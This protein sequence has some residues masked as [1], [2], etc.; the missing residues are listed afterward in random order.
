MLNQIKKFKNAIH[1]YKLNNG[2][3]RSDISCCPCCNSLL[4]ETNTDHIEY[5]L[6]ECT[7]YCP[8]CQKDVGVWAYGNLDEDSI[9]TKLP[10]KTKEKLLSR[11]WRKARNE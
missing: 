10:Q 3:I 9:Y 2:F 7:Y 8:R 1:I 4:E 5:T 6:C 11:M